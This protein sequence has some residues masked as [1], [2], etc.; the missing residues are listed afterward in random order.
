MSIENAF[1]NKTDRKNDADQAIEGFLRIKEV[2]RI[3]PV[4]RSHWW[5]GVKKGI[6][7]SPV[8]L[9]VRVSAWRTEDIKRLIESRNEECRR[10]HK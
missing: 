4:S 10:L 2:L 3:Y 1:L 9:S 6:Y 5:S 8:K 7:P